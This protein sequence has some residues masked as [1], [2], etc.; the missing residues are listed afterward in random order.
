MG[1]TAVAATIREQIGG[2]ALYMLGAKNFG[3]NGKD[4]VFKIGRNSKGVTHIEIT[5]NSLDLYDVKFYACRGG[6]TP[7]IKTKAEHNNVYSDML[8]GII[9]KETELYLSL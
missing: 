7:S 8:N 3:T 5:L 6:L 1:T 4:L 9:Q 2:K